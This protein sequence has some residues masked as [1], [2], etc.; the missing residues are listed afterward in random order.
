MFPDPTTMRCVELMQWSK[1][2][3][4]E[5]EVADRARFVELYDKLAVQDRR[6]QL[7][8]SLPAMQRYRAIE[9][10]RREAIEARTGGDAPDRSVFGKVLA[11]VTGEEP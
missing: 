7:S 10:G 11:L 4:S 2:C 5:N 6:K 3:S 8:E 9:A 1:L